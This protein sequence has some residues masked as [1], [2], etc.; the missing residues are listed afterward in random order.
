MAQNTANFPPL[1]QGL[2]VGYWT[3]LLLHEKPCDHLGPNM[4]HDTMNGPSELRYTFATIDEN[5]DVRNLAASDFFQQQAPIQ[6]AEEVTSQWK[7]KMAEIG[8]VMT[9]STQKVNNGQPSRVIAATSAEVG[10]ALRMIDGYNA[11]IVSACQRV[12]FATICGPVP[13]SIQALV[14]Q[15]AA[16]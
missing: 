11:S 13:P 15:P 16:D 4:V 6:V 7:R 9:L 1:I 12:R 2:E 10:E 5:D 8:S 14:A 3:L